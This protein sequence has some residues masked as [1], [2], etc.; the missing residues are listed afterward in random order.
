MQRYPFAV[1]FIRNGFKLDIPDVVAEVTEQYR[2]RENWLENFVSD[3]CIREPNARVGARD[4]YLAYKDWAADA[5]EYV[6]RENDF[7]AA[8]E[9]AGYRKIKPKGK[10][11][12]EG[13]SLDYA[14]KFGS[15]WA[16]TG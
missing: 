11:H 2:E 7:S 6:C 16:A 8:M 4:L 14:A 1:N 12:Y 15:P 13:L 9:L 10:F 3:R 5:G